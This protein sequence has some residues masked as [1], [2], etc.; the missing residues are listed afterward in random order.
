MLPFLCFPAENLNITIICCS[1]VLKF[2]GVA[3]GSSVLRF[4]KWNIRV[5]LKIRPNQSLLLVL[6]NWQMFYWQ[7]FLDA[8]R[9]NM[10]STVFTLAGKGYSWRRIEDVFC[11]G[12]IQVCWCMCWHSFEPNCHGAVMLSSS[13]VLKIFLCVYTS[14]FICIVNKPLFAFTWMLPTHQGFPSE[15]RGTFFIALPLN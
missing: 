1:A 10:S 14:L 2:T 11:S 12:D 3:I 13:H 5:I 8:G 6:H 7:T 4:A 9:L 15:D